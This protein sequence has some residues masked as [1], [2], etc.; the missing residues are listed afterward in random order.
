[1]SKWQQDISLVYGVYKIKKYSKYII[2]RKNF[3]VVDLFRKVLNRYP[4]KIL[5]NINGEEIT[6][7]IL[8]NRSNQVA[9]W[10]LSQGFKIGDCVPIIMDSSFTYLVIWL[11]LAKVGVQAVLINTNLTGEALNHSLNVAYSLNQSNRDML[12]T[13]IISFNLYPNLSTLNLSNTIQ[14]FVV[15]DSKRPRLDSI[16]KQTIPL[17]IK[18][19]QNL[20]SL[21]KNQ[22]ETSPSRDISGISFNDPL[23][24]IFTSGTTGMPK[25]AKISHMRFAV[26]G[27]AFKHLYG[28]NKTDTIY[29]PL[30]LYHSNGGMVGISSAWQCGMNIII[31]K[32]FSASQYFTDCKENR[33]TVGVYIGE[34]CRYI[35]NSK[36][37]PND[38]NHQMKILIGNGMRPEVWQPFVD[39]FQIKI[40]EFYGSTEGNANLFNTT[41]KPGAVGYLPHLLKLIYPVKI[42]QYDLET[43]LPIKNEKGFCQTVPND[44]PGCLI[45]LINN[46]DATRKFDGYTDK[47][48]TQKKILSNVFKTNDQWFNTGDL[49]KMD[50]EGYIY[51]VDRIGDTFRWKGENV[52]TS[53]VAQVMSKC[54]ELDD[55]N[56]YGISLPGYDGCIGMA[57]ITSV[58]GINYHTLYQIL[59]TNLPNYAIPYFLR[60]LTN[61]NLTNSNLTNSNLTATFKHKK[62]DLRREGIHIRDTSKILI[63]NPKDKTYIPIRK[64]DYTEI[65]T[66]TKRF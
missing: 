52:A 15:I 42:I 46:Q 63:L 49:V 51:F 1:M 4:N 13:I 55:C 17:D 58:K 18:P 10:A 21:L 5:K 8:D 60:I 26:A 36:P 23:F 40:G 66:T 16:P 35:L 59:E 48:S 34:C 50:K 56:V 29:I 7:R 19:E 22:R 3:T 24:Y 57:A 44:T 27:Y 43:E 2:A 39:R 9:N 62:V 37:N 65:Q 11:G 31:R 47:K 12:K 33:C 54:P 6:N 61:S 53:E 25:A 20:L 32:N 41:G 30:P 38:K 28:L 64:S 45:G 14:I